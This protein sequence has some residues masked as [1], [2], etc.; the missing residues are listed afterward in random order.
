MPML[1]TLIDVSVLLNIDIY[2]AAAPT[3]F[4]A[5]RPFNCNASGA[6]ATGPPAAFGA[7]TGAAAAG[8][9]NAGNPAGS[10]ASVS[11]AADTAS[12][13]TGGAAATD[14]ASASTATPAASNGK[15]RPKKAG[16][17]N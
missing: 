10:S 12:A 3:N 2:L 5:T 9:N 4:K 13:T 8:S 14:S 6:I 1:S 16:K 17:G 7:T 11:S 15:N